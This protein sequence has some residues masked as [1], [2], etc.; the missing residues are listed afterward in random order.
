MKTLTK[1]QEDAGTVLVSIQV[2]MTLAE[3]VSFEDHTIAP[4]L[5]PDAV[6]AVLDQVC[7]AVKADRAGFCGAP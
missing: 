2:E 6:I 5:K 1:M 4:T 3:W 7:R